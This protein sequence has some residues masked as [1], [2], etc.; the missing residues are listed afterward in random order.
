MTMTTYYMRVTIPELPEAVRVSI[1]SVMH[2]GSAEACLKIVRREAARRG[3]AAE[4]ELST[5]EEYVAFR[6][7]QREAIEAASLAR[8]EH[9][10]SGSQ[11]YTR[12]NYGA[13]AGHGE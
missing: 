1:N 7:A 12:V 8:D 9:R 6:R 10:V 3:V 13:D 2:T 11:Q 5:R 4:Y